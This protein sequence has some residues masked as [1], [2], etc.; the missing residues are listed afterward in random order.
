LLYFWGCA[1]QHN[2]CLHT[3]MAKKK[4][5]STKPKKHGRPSKYNPAFNQQAEKLCKLGATDKELA[6]FFEV[7]EDTINEWKKV[8]PSFSVSVREGKICADVQVANALFDG[9]HDRIVI[10]QQAFKV[11]EVKW[12]NGKR[13]EKETVEMVPVEKVIPADFRNQQFWL[14]NRQKDKWRDK[15]ELDLNL[16][17]E[18]EV[19]IT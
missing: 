13:V 12:L 10:E 5:T 6:D 3:S 19:N 7:N 2:S 9:C 14:K 1:L 18:V 16:D 4:P 11:K 8:Y 17:G 15:Q